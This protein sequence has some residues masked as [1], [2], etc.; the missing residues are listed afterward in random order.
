[1]INDRERR[2]QARV[3]RQEHNIQRNQLMAQQGQQQQPPAA[4]AFSLTPA[5][6]QRV[7][8]NYNEC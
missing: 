7:A 3:L 8:L 2:Y 5:Y 4:P 1:M 6:N